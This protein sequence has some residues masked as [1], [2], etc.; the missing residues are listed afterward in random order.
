MAV[1][2]TIGLFGVNMHA[3]ADPH[4][5]ALIAEA[6]ES[7]GYDS[8]WVADHVVLPSPRDDDSPM[9]PREPLLDPVVALAY[10]ASRTRGIRLGSACIVLPQRNPLVLAK[11]LAS[12]DVLSGGRLIA[13]LAVGYL[14]RELR[15]VGVPLRGRGA[16]TEEYLRAMRSLWHDESPACRGQFVDFDGVDAFPRPVQRPLPVALGGHSTAAMR[17]ALTMADGWIGW[18]LGTRAAAEHLQTLRLLAEQASRTAPLHISICPA[19]R[20]NP[21]VV[22][23]FAELGV[24]R[25][26]LVP[27][28]GLSLAELEDFVIDNA[29]AR[30]GARPVPVEPAATRFQKH[31]AAHRT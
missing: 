13:G 4:G 1:P 22:A 27:R 9:D 2:P 17:R 11:Q 26:V 14:E 18:M 31:P 20:M 23:A 5:A 8:L 28:P 25:L 29:P 6:A 21:D 12:I 7:L 3:C 10:L 30:L 19:R 24:D 15:A 16:R